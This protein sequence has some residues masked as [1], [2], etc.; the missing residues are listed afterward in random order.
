[1]FKKL[2][3]L[4]LVLTLVL[5]LFAGCSGN[6]EKKEDTSKTVVEK[7]DKKETDKKE[8]DKK[9]TDKKDSDKKDSEVIFNWNLGGTVETL[10]PGLNA[11][12][13]TGN[14]I[15]NTFEGL[16]REVDGKPV[17]AV[18][19]SYTVSDDN[20][21][22]TFILNDN[23]LWS[24]GKEVTAHDFEYAWKRNYDPATASDYSWIFNEFNYESCK[25]IDD[26]TFE[27]TLKAPADYFVGLTAFSTLMPL[28]QDAVESKAD[29]AWATDP[30]KVISNGP[31]ILTE[32]IPGDRVVLE[33]ND[34]YFKA[35]EV[36]IDKI[37]A[38]IVTEETAALAEYESGGFDLNT[39]V[40]AAEIPRLLV[41]DPTFT[42]VARP[43]TYYFSLNPNQVPE[44][45]DVR[46]RQAISL[47][48]DRVAITD[49]LNRGSIPAISFIPQGVKDANG[50]EFTEKA[51]VYG[52]DIYDMEGN[53]AK[54]KKLMAA[55][56]FPNGEGFPTINYITNT[57]EG[58]LL[59]A[60]QVQD[61]L[62]V[63]LGI[64]MEISSSEW[65]VF[66]ET[67]KTH[68]F[69]MARGG[70]TGDYVDPL[71]FIGFYTTGNPLNS[72][73][74]SN[75]DYD[76]LIAKSGETTGQE[77]YDVLAAAEKILVEEAWFIPVYHYTE[78]IH[79]K[80]YV[81][82]LER[83]VLGKLYFGRVTIEDH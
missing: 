2:F 27:V 62:Q 81:K 67:R 68:V 61:A 16:M 49:M 48:V 44:L 19:K 71:T 45:K 43:G 70:W 64:K 14:V 51:A 15:N 17:F 3:A 69:D 54:A 82:G 12:T 55:A 20:L 74:W 50:Q 30:E 37:I 28:R 83:T 41:E 36:K 57:G 40:P 22:Y 6:N 72:P 78:S 33:K 25:A 60:Q 11:A 73:E 8:T 4:M 31:F 32:Y 10:D 18:A 9:E 24:D 13:N 7:T 58:H 53:I 29:G 59:V 46:V 63:N 76:A 21:V 52:V 39:A 23:F 26:K 5:S 1:M 34:L 79:K 66:Q 65:A 42:V 75:T 80:A 35:D 56:G 77:R 38:K 47:V